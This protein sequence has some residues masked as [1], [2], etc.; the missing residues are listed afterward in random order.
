MSTP[1]VA[2]QITHASHVGEARRGALQ[3][4]GSAGL[5]ES[6]AGRV[7]LIVTEAGTN[8][9][10]H[11]REGQILA[12]GLGGGACA[13]VEIYALDRGPGIANLAESLRDGH[14]TAGTPGT[15]LGALSRLASRFDIYSRPGKGVAVWCEVWGKD[16]PAEHG[17]LAAGAICVPKPG[18]TA[19]GDGWFARGERDRYIVMLVDGLGHGIDA[20]AAAR[21]ATEAVKAHPRRNAADI[22]D[23]M[24]G[25]LRSTRG[26]AA[27]LAVVKPGTEVGEFCGVG[28]ITC[29]TRMEGKSRSLVSHNGILGHQV[30]RLQE[31]AF[32]FPPSALLIMHSDGLTARWSL[33][34]Y[35]G[36]EARHPAVIAGVL[37]RD[38]RRGTDDASVLVARHVNGAA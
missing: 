23:S 9:V 28:N 3:L 34:D 4:A 11:A 36:L 17:P 13:G 14:S 19:C 32:A 15:G 5:G 8:I 29:L 21:A 35:P 30:R 25:A 20:A 27:A 37:F 24:H 2:F 6:D 12:R 22:A 38:F 1:H 26:A 7:A 16:A 18:E 33:D 10:K 31:F